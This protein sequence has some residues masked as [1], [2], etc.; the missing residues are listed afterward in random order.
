MV[1][2]TSK[3]SKELQNIRTIS[4]LIQNRPG[5]WQLCQ[6]LD[7]FF[8]E[9]PNG[10]HL[11]L[12]QELLGPTLGTVL[13]YYNSDKDNTEYL[14]PSTILNISKQLLKTVASLHS[15]GISHGGTSTTPAFVSGRLYR[16]GF[17]FQ[18][19]FFSLADSE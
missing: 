18:T 11:C 3:G 9:G 10:K 14:R 2:D 17:F 15:V 19:A 8:Y 5:S 12:V 13:D 16:F 7:H 1:A 6:L 4:Q